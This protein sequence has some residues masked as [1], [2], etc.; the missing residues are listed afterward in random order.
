MREVRVIDTL[1]VLMGR[2]AD[3]DPAAFRRVMAELE[4]RDRVVGKISTK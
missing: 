3:R 1:L 2:L 4:E